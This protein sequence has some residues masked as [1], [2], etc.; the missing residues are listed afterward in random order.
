ML[1]TM[2]LVNV[3]MSHPCRWVFFRECTDRGI[4]RA[5]LAQHLV[6]AKVMVRTTCILRVPVGCLNAEVAGDR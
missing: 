3:L 1:C 2:T 6:L 5:C 4:Q